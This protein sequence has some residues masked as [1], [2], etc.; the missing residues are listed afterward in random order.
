NQA[1]WEL[2]FTKNE[3]SGEKVKIDNLGWIDNS[4][5]NKIVHTAGSSY[6]SNQNVRY[7]IDMVNHNTVLRLREFAVQSNGS[8]TNHLLATRELNIN[9]YVT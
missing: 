6:R 5:A 4:T 2:K 1:V 7:A 8:D 3:L 9:D